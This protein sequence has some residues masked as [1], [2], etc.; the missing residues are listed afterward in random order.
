M[1]LAQILVMEPA[2][3][4]LSQVKLPVKGGYRVSKLILAFSKEAQL[5]HEQRNKLLQDL[6]KPNEDGSQFMLR[7]EAVDGSVVFD[8]VKEF[9]EQI[10][11]L[12]EVDVG[13]FDKIKLDD[14]GSAQIEPQHLL[15]L[16]GLIE[17]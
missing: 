12:L 9:N 15:A 16:D 3:Q 7:E 14:F 2:L 4:A 8:N 5:Y 13:E 11:S 6:G 1:K 17:P 10:N